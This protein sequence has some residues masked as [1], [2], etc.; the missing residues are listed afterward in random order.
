VTIPDTSGQRRGATKIRGSGTRV[1]V[2]R[3]VA[4]GE[5]GV[6]RSAAIVLVLDNSTGVAA[7]RTAGIEFG[8]TAGDATA[9]VE[10][11]G[12]LGVLSAENCPLRIITSRARE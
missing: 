10:A 2:G 5:P 11:T 4:G 12:S 7:G 9:V 1:T 3:D 6:A 8:S